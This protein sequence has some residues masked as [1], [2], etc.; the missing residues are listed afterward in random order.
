MKK[1]LEDARIDTKTKL[2]VL[3]IALMFFYV[4]NDVISF[5]RKDTME[6]VMSGE[7]GAGA[8]QV[9]PVFLLSASMLMAIPIFMVY[10]SLTLPAG[11]NRPVN[12]IVGILHVLLLIVTA[13]V[14]GE[15]WAHYAL[16]MVF[17]AVIMF[18]I[19]W[20]AWKWPTQNGPS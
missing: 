14:P 2:S 4:Y 12:I 15:T 17:E 1:H 18:L 3:W 16:F 13:L 8:I 5:Y 7:F 9:T 6:G 11:V 19:I 10:L 20:H